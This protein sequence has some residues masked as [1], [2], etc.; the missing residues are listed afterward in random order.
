MQ[1]RGATVPL[2][3]VVATTAVLA[4][5]ACGAGS[6]PGGSP[7]SRSTAAG[8]LSEPAGVIDEFART[9]FG[10][11]YAGI[12]LSD[13]RIKVYRT[14]VQQ[15]ADFDLSIRDLDLGVDVQILDAPYSAMQLQA[16]ADRVTQDIGYWQSMGISISSVGARQN[17]T[18]VDVGM[19][20]TDDAGRL[21]DERYVAEPPVVLQKN[22]PVVTVSGRP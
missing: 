10:S 21:F 14:A 13:G 12:E 5:A 8:D 4:L 1:K 17:G 20:A 16:L 22:G 2:L 3:V 19:T 15:P 9:R 6:A 18:A 7:G 11:Q